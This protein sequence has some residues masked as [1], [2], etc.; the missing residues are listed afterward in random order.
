[1]FTCILAFLLGASSAA[2]DGK[3]LVPKNY[4]L[5]HRPVINQS[6]AMNISVGMVITQILHID[7]KDSAL[8]FNIEFIISWVDELIGIEEGTDGKVHLKN[9][10]DIWTPDLY[11]YD[12]IKFD[13]QNIFNSV[14]HIVL[15][16]NGLNIKVSH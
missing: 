1:M 14:S 4:S 5:F 2:P 13:I 3:V 7:L 10:S 6:K 16:K 12:L 15:T 11:I 9:A 8:D